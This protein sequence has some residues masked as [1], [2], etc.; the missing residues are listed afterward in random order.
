MSTKNTDLDDDNAKF[1]EFLQGKGEL[2]EL[3]RALPQEQPSSEL[4]AKILADAR[5]S[6]QSSLMKTLPHRQR[7]RK[8]P[9]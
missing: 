8:N 3:L 9:N 6:L 7:L 4:D 2:S 5:R 1:D